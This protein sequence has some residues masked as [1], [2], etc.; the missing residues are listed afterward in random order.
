M[1]KKII[2]VIYAVRVQD[3]H[4]IIG[5]R[6]SC[7]GIGELGILKAPAIHIKQCLITLN[8]KFEKEGIQVPSHNYNTRQRNNVPKAPRRRLAS[9]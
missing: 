6:D 1:I 8:I 7:R 4:Q 3:V 9:C 5:F 2:V